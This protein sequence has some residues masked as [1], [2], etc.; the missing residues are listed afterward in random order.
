MNYKPNANA[1]NLRTGDSHLFGVIVP[2]I[3]M[4]FFS[5]VIAGI[6]EVA[7]RKNYNIIICQS[8]DSFEKEEECIQT[9]I[10]QNV[11]CI[12][13]SLAAATTTD[14]HLKEIIARDIQLIQFDRVNEKLK[15]N[16]V[17]NNEDGIF[18][19]IDHLLLQ[20][21]QR[22]AHLAG[23]QNISIYWKR[24]EA[25]IAA[26]RKK[27]IIVN[28]NLI[29]S[30]CFTKEKAVTSVRRLLRMKHRPDAII[31]SADF[32]TL[33]ALEVARELN[34]KVPEELGICGYA[35]EGFTELTTP[36]L[37]SINQHSFDMGVAV[38]NLFFDQVKDKDTKENTRK[39]EIII[40][41]QLITRSSSLRKDK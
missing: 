3:N 14:K 18:Q 40:H 1:S 29:A 16:K 38:A 28:K 36:A 26:L 23:P 31:A 27:Q 7:N 35:N 34:I 41:S 32:M 21:Y 5:D 24:K 19:A 11:A 17:V 33:A 13:I 10:N 6:E 30:D 20:G 39:K 2:R 4:T 8:H 9:L 12:M 25:F 15:T 22:I 37:S